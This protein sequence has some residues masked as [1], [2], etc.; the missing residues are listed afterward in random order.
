[1]NADAV[2]ETVAATM[3]PPPRR[4]FLPVATPLEVHLL[5]KNPRDERFPKENEMYEDDRPRTG[6][7]PPLETPIPQ[8]DRVSRTGGTEQPAA[9]E[10]TAVIAT[11][12]RAE[13]VVDANSSFDGRFET[14]QDLRI[15]GTISGEIIC[16]GRFTIERDAT[17]KTKIQAHEAHIKGKLEGDIV[18]SGLLV[19]ASTAVVS[20]TIKAATLVVEEGA[21]LSGTV[22]TAKTAL[23]AGNRPTGIARERNGAEPTVAPESASAGTAPANR[24]GRGREVPSFALVSSESTDR[25]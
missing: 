13:S 2:G 17:A 22:E 21:S 7:I 19:V 9:P 3:R 6:A 1:M 8:F 23:P 15:E 18:C 5:K 10:S 4:A 16:R 12:T 11:S 14:D 24:P 25:N 20:G